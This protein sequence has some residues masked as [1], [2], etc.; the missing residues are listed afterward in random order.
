MPRSISTRSGRNSA[1]AATASS[2][3]CAVCTS[4]PDRR[5]SI[6]SIFAAARLSSTTSTRCRT[7]GGGVGRFLPRRRTVG[8]HRSGR[9]RQADTEL[10]A[11]ALPVA[12]DRHRPAR[13]SRPAT[14]PSSARCP[15]R[16]SPPRSPARGR[17]PSGR[18]IC[19]NISK[20]ESRIPAGMP[21]PSSRTDRVT[22]PAS[23]AS[24]STAAP[25]A[26]FPAVRGVLDRVAQQVREDLGQPGGRRRRA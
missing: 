7:A 16:S 17:P 11:A 22:S 3:S 6:P 1:A 15:G 21:S 4:C 19:R 25:R 10:A 24:G 18:S 26:T 9:Q 23:P 14:A 2:P 5:T 13:A 12:A 20:I 8:R